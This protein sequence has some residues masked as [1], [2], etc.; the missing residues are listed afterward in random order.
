MINVVVVDDVLRLRRDT[1]EIRSK[2]MELP[3]TK[4]EEEAVSYQLSLFISVSDSLS[5]A[6]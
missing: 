3:S 6:F 5:F 2:K 4:L 1:D